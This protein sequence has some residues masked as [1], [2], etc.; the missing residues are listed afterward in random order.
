MELDIKKIA[1]ELIA[2]LKQESENNNQ[3]IIGVAMLFEAIREVA[4]S[5]APA[6]EKSNEPG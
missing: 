6:Q 5:Q 1:E 3:R 4:A 2:K